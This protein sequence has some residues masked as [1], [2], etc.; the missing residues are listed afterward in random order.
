M[1]NVEFQR[2]KENP[3]FYF[4]R[5]NFFLIKVKYLFNN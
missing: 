1:K 5:N 3:N 2:K 4:E